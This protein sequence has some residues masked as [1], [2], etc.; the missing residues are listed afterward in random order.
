[1]IIWHYLSHIYQAKKDREV[2]IQLLYFTVDTYTLSLQKN[3]Y[4][5]ISQEFKEYRMADENSDEVQIINGLTQTST[6][7]EETSPTKK[8]EQTISD[9]IKTGSKRPCASRQ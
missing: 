5:P 4:Y 8:P 7:P 9:I 2:L 6:Y 1:M 3:Y